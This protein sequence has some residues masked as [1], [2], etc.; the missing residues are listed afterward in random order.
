MKRIALMLIPVVAIACV[1]AK[2]VSSDHARESASAPRADEARVANPYAPVDQEPPPKLTVYAPDPEALAKGVVWIQYKVE[3]LRIVPVF[4]EGAL[5]VSPRV[6]HLHVH[7][8][9]LPWW[10]ADPSNTGTVDLAGMPPGEHKV[11]I[12]LVDPDHR[13]F[14]GQ[15]KTVKFTVPGTARAAPGAAPGAAPALPPEDSAAK[16][17]GEGR[18]P[19][20]YRDWRL[21][22][23]AR[24]EADLDDI[25]AV[26]GNDAAIKAYR[27]GSTSSY[28]DG[29]V[30]ARLAWSFDASEENNR[31]FGRQQSFVAGHPKNG[32]Q[33]M[34]KDSTKYASTGGWG[35][36]QFDDG[37]PLTD[38]AML[39]SCF[40]CHRAVKDRDYVFTR[41]AK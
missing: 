22:S 7:V 23:V 9:D 28:P 11:R 19:D 20:G 38:R 1:V 2:A 4:G 29:T 12:E 35:Y 21:I 27:E 16:A 37:K 24:E 39:Q 14:P 30:I 25:R 40:E 34:V 32:V 31:S 13:T 26:L 36:S 10:W 15:S 5:G 8:D 17:I 41:Y 33:F 3:N 18:L 6:G